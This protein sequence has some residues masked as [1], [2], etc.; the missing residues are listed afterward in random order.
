MSEERKTTVVTG[1]LRDCHII[2][3]RILEIALEEAGFKVV[4]LGALISQ[5]DFIKAAIETNAAAILISSLYGMGMLDCRGMREKC[6]ETGLGDI[7][8]YVGG[9]LSVGS[10]AR[11]KEVERTFKEMGFDRVYPP[12]TRPPKVIQDLKSDLGL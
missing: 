12:R 8:L 10:E 1:A 6:K 4:K 5:E 11:W 3:L 7:L 9:Q 2:G